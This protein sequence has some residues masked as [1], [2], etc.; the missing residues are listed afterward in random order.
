MTADGSMGSED[1]CDSIMMIE[2]MFAPAAEHTGGLRAGAAPTASALC[3][4]TQ[5]CPVTTWRGPKFLHK[6]PAPMAFV[7]GTPPPRGFG[8]G[9][10]PGGGPP[11]QVEPE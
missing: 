3:C 7:R 11:S 8:R 4:L 10:A 5:C 1:R 2:R 9:A 6:S